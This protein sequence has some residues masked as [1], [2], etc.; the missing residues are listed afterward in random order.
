MTKTYPTARGEIYNKI[1]KKYLLFSAACDQR[2]IPSSM[3]FDE[4]NAKEHTKAVHLEDSRR[5][6]IWKKANKELILVCG[7]LADYEEDQ[8]RGL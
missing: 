7:E 2:M 4:K 1:Y 8:R 5:D 6:E 3:K